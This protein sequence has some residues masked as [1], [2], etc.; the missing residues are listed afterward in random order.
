MFI[1]VNFDINLKEHPARSW[2]TVQIPRLPGTSHKVIIVIPSALI[3]LTFLQTLLISNI[4]Y[5]FNLGELSLSQEPEPPADVSGSRRRSLSES[6]FKKQNSVKYAKSTSDSTTPDVSTPI[7]NATLK[8][9]GAVNAVYAASR[10]KPPLY[11]L[12]HLILEAYFLLN[13]DA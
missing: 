2:L 7:Y 8:V 13:C 11:V 10:M 12:R 5:L 3:E 1:V 4:L 6:T 9:K